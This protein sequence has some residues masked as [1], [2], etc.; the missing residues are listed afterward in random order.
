MKNARRRSFNNDFEADVFAGLNANPKHLNSKYFYD[1]QG[2]AL[3]Q[4]IMAL[5]EYYLCAREF[6]IIEANKRKMAELFSAG[7]GFD[8][9]EFGAGDG[10]K[11]KV[12]LRHLHARQ[13][14]FKYCP[15]DIS[16]NAVQQLCDSLKQ[17]L[18]DL[19]VEPHIGTYAQVLTKLADY[20]ERKK[21]ILFL[22][23]NIGNFTLDAAVSFLQQIRASMGRDDRLLVGFDQKKHPQR[24]LDAYRDKAGV[25]EAFNKNL[26]RR[27]NRELGAHFDPDTFVYWPVYQPEESVIK[28]YLVSKIAQQVYIEALDFKACF[29]PWESIHTE[30]SQK[31]DDPS[32]RQLA[33]QAGLVVTEV[34]SDANSDY[35]NYIFRN[36]L[37][38]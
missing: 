32:I 33:Q 25:T 1:A 7:G 21:L 37:V 2:D 18:P 24:I 10:K 11:T 20:R 27:M 38:I 14:D 15:V 30:N 16:E 6:D 9:V 34:F 4:K 36:S 22:G 17:T 8:L 13:V 26:L 31:F 23:S 35:R 28:S 5:S 19:R 3:F 29:Q 12:L